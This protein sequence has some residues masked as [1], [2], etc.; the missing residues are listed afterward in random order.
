MFKF[1]FPIKAMNVNHYR[2]IGRG[3]SYKSKEAKIFEDRFSFYMRHYKHTCLKFNAVYDDSE[4]CIAA[5]Y[6]IGIKCI[7]KENKIAKRKHDLDNFL[8]PINDQLFKYLDA[9]DSEIM[10]IQAV[11]VNSDEPFISIG[12]SLIPLSKI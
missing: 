7:T 2:K 10:Q 11:K 6:T 5:F 4:Y 9:D 12:L 8:K 3:R 1:K